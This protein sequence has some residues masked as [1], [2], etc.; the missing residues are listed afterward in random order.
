MSREHIVSIVVSAIALIFA[1]SVSL[2][3]SESDKPSTPT[4]QKAETTAD[5][6]DRVAASS[7]Y[8]VIGTVK[9]RDRTIVI[10]SGPDGPLYSVRDKNGTVVSLELSEKDLQAQHPGIYRHIKG[11]LAGGVVWAGM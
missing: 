2:A 3:H 10:V 6:G 8:P 11:G 9:T 7:E 1:G 5:V 4:I